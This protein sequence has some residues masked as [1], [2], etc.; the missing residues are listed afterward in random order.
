M[1][2]ADPESAS[3]P[4]LAFECW[5]R[6]ASRPAPSPLLL[7][8]LPASRFC[9]LRHRLLAVS[10]HWTPFRSVTGHLWKRTLPRS[11]GKGHGLA[12]LR[13]GREVSANRARDEGRAKKSFVN[14]G[15]PCTEDHLKGAVRAAQSGSRNALAKVSSTPRSS[16]AGFETCSARACALRLG[17]GLRTRLAPAFLGVA[18]FDDVWDRNSWSRSVWK[19]LSTYN[20]HMRA[21]VEAY[22]VKSW[23][24]FVSQY[25]RWHVLF[26][27]FMVTICSP[28]TFA[29][30]PASLRFSYLRRRSRGSGAPISAPCVESS[31]AVAPPSA[32]VPETP[33]SREPNLKPPA[34]MVLIE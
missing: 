34:T 22:E 10:L 31:A 29:G 26:M 11:H 8:P 5:Q 4:T 7:H 28:V 14:V 33:S 23:N 19:N 2:L 9:R 15:P 24:T 3:S 16:P 6:P 18:L 27:S 1:W 12:N 32:E 20:E 25:Q 13:L 17:L 30:R 21:G